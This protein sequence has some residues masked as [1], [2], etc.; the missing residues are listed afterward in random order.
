MAQV[1]QA[2]QLRDN[3]I[4]NRSFLRLN[5]V[6]EKNQCLN[7]KVRKNSNVS[8]NSITYGLIIVAKLCVNV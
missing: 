8:Q 6:D 5:A 7:M 1:Q 2:A 4:K 3:V